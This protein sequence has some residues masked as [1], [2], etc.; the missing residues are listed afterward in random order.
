MEML[1]KQY[2][3]IQET[4]ATV[5]QQNPYLVSSIRGEPL[6]RTKP[7]TV[8]DMVLLMELIPY[9]TDGTHLT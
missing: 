9:N 5:L 8:C 2:L 3:G 7:V 4:H 6:K 1:V